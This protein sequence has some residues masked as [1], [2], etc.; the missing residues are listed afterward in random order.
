MLSIKSQLPSSRGA[1]S[2]PT[3]RYPRA[4]QTFSRLFIMDVVDS[5]LNATSQ[6]IFHPISSYHLRRSQ[7]STESGVFNG[8]NKLTA[9]VAAAIEDK[10]PLLGVFRRV[11]VGKLSDLLFVTEADLEQSDIKLVP[12]RKFLKA[13]FVL[14]HSLAAQTGW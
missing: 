4:G 1:G 13:V 12:R 7:R 8:T 14:K 11:G 6:Y 5:D 2:K 9:Y 10:T 3:H